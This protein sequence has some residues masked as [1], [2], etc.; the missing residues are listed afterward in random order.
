VIDIEPGHAGLAGGQL[1]AVGAHNGSN[2]GLTGCCLVRVL[3]GDLVGDVYHGW[4]GGKGWM[5]MVPAH[6]PMHEK[7]VST[8]FWTMQCNAV[9]GGKLHTLDGC[10]QPKLI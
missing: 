9:Y 1:L 5:G 3:L 8:A 10:Y 4:E 7:L 2:V 6:N